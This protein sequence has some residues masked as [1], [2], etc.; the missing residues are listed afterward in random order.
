MKGNEKNNLDRGFKE[1]KIDLEHLF[2][3]D[4]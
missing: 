3:M 2:L 4:K 1:N